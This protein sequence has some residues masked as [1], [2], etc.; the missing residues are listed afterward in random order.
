MTYHQ[1]DA[2]YAGAGKEKRG[3]PKDTWLHNIR[4]D[5]KETFIV[6]F[7]KTPTIML[8]LSARNRNEQWYFDGRK[9]F[10]QHIGA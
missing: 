3:R 4:E 7:T 1:E 6:T 10:E 2:K 8:L 5:M 9:H